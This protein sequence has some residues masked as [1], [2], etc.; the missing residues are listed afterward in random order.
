M[1]D[2]ATC[3]GL[4]TAA[5]MEN[6]AIREASYTYPGNHVLLVTAIVTGGIDKNGARAGDVAYFAENRGIYE[7]EDQKMTRNPGTIN[8]ILYI[9]ASMSDDAMARTIMHATEAKVAALEELRCPSLYGRGQATG[10][11]TDGIILVCH[12]HDPEEPLHLT[13]V[14]HMTK[15]GELVSVTVKEA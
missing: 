14:N 5:Q 8:I 13:A 6:A 1:L 3:T 4:T 12:D 10:S 2:P 11:G 9:H 15:A 7:S